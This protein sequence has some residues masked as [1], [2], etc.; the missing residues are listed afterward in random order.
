MRA[1]RCRSWLSAVRAA[2]L[3]GMAATGSTN[4]DAKIVDR[5]GDPLSAEAIAEIGDPLFRF[6]IRDHGNVGDLER[7]VD[8]IKGPGDVT[9]LTFVVD[10]RIASAEPVV[11]DRPQSRRAVIAFDGTRDGTRLNGNVMLSVF[12]LSNG[13]PTPPPFVEGWGW[14]EASGQY[15]YYRVDRPGPGVPWVFE[16]SSSDVD[17]MSMADRGGTCFR[18]H[19]NGAPVMKELFFP[20]NNWHSFRAPATYLEPGS[21][22]EAWPVANHQLLGHLT[23]A[24]TLESRLI[25]AIRNF[26]VR[27]I[28]ALVETKPNGGRV[29][30]DA[31]RLL[32]PIFETTEVNLVSAGQISGLHPLTGQPI[33]GPTEP[34]KVPASFLINTALIADTLDRDAAHAFTDVVNIEPNEYRSLIQSA[35]VCLNGQTLGDTLFAWLVPEVGQVDNDYVDRLVKQQLVSLAFLAA[36]LSVDLETPVF[37]DAREL[38]LDVLPESFEVSA[39]PEPHPDSLTR[40]V[41]AALQAASPGAGTSAR[42]FL[43]AL[44]AP[45]PGALLDQKLESYRT[46]LETALDP[47]DAAQRTSKLKELYEIAVKRRQAML[48]P[49]RVFHN[50]DETQGRLLFP[51]PCS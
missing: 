40:A 27:R 48:S 24:E 30:A 19:T 43:D 2:V 1:N 7:M 25:S 45:D 17:L 6:L 26:N 50:L 5:Q 44:S 51:L 3:V 10:E 49:E 16:G 13:F 47:A 33:A 41:I 8:L 38:L 34:V 35:G 46:G 28:E 14:D 15:N 12:L 36:A 39:T 21:G 4:A 32:R 22:A 11:N 37:S 29:V 9:V 18:C 20:W 42:A 23:S 31:R